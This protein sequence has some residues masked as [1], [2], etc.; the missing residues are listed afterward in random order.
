M[1]ISN[2]DARHNIIRQG[3]NHDMHALCFQGSTA[4]ALFATWAPSTDGE[5]YRLASV[6]AGIVALAGASQDGVQIPLSSG[7]DYNATCH[8][9]AHK[10][11]TATS[12]YY[13]GDPSGNYTADNS[14]WGVT[15]SAASAC[16]V[17]PG[18]IA[19]IRE[20]LYIVAE[21]K[22]PFAIKCGGHATN[23]GFSSTR[24]VQ[25]A[26]RR[27][28]KVVV[29]HAAGTIDIGGGLRWDQVYSA[30]DGT[31][32][33]VVGGR[34]MGVGVS[35]LT[36]GGGYSWKSNEYGLTL[37]NVVGF[38]VVLPNGTVTTVTKADKDLWFA[39]RGGGNNFGIVTKFTMKSVPQTDVWGG[40]AVYS[41]DHVDSVISAVAKF[42]ATAPDK[43]AV[44]L[45]SFS[46]T[47]QGGIMI[48]LLMFY[49]GPSPPSGV[50]DDFLAIHY[51]VLSVRTQSFVSFVQSIARPP[52][53]ARLRFSSVPVLDWTPSL[54]KV[55]YNESQ[56]WSARLAPLENPPPFVS[57]QL[58][59]MDPTYLQHGSPSAWPPSRKYPFLP[60][61]LF[62]SW[63]NK[64]SDSAMLDA[65]HK[66][67]ATIRAAASAEG[68]NITN[69][70][71]YPNYALEDTPVKEMYGDNVARLRAIHKRVDP[72]N[73][74]GLTGGFKF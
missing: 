4:T 11:S 31:G 67:S 3:Q 23:P 13:P 46:N 59:T 8:A 28:N 12:V 62:F 50:F 35:G 74:M 9:I 60:G 51:E 20:I 64:S 58:D 39:L 63:A 16:S 15:S 7:R 40:V 34:I 24:G 10:V 38:E 22:T 57:W 32:L 44:V 41:I 1:Q 43:K 65:F 26:M 55:V 69:A 49:D 5:I 36:L 17:E 33:S 30:L 70:W 21:T 45:P 2:Q 68:Q 14:H 56:Y 37:D 48:G 53:G 66:S 71:T 29:N 47:P 19:D 6:G 54:L 25:I 42:S 73:T 61:A 18:S 52:D 27:F 72:D